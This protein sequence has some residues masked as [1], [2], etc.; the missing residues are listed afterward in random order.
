[1]QIFSHFPQPANGR[2]IARKWDKFRAVR[3]QSEAAIPMTTGA[4]LL[5]P[6]SPSV[7]LSK[8][9]NISIN[10]GYNRPAQE[11]HWRTPRDSDY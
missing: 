3:P 6:L 11:T 5:P 1:V 7:G 8:A 4:A 2:K 9:A 10:R